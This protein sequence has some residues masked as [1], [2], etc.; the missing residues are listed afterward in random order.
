MW[1]CGGG[2][3]FC[4]TRRGK[5]MCVYLR[6]AAPAS[7]SCHL[8]FA[9]L[10]R[11]L[12]LSHTHT[13]TQHTTRINYISSLCPLCCAPVARLHRVRAAAHYAHQMSPR[14]RCKTKLWFPISDNEDAI[15]AFLFDHPKGCEETSRFDRK[16]EHFLML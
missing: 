13:Y 11:S 4:L 5:E 14:T 1:I 6:A 3:L 9:F 10:S 7:D 12:T 16:Q 15:I 8:T 2:D